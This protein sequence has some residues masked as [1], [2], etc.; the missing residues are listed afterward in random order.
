MVVGFAAVGATL[1]AV[2]VAGAGM[3]VGRR[4][5]SYVRVFDWGP[6]LDVVADVEAVAFGIFAPLPPS[7]LVVL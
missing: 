3:N 6:A 1:E 5:P 2:L 4:F 7:R